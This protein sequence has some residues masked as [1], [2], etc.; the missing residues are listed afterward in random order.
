MINVLC[1][2]YIIVLIK[3]RKKF[4]ITI[5]DFEV[6]LKVAGYKRSCC[7]CEIHKKVETREDTVI[8]MRS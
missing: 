8:E 5:P 3:K 1:Y 2:Q 6:L 4:K 7:M